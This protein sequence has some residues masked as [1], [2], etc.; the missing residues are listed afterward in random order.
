MP[1]LLW[2]VVTEGPSKEVA[3][4]G[5]EEIVA[6]RENSKCLLYEARMSLDV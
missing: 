6:G 1:G 5:L 4:E 2:I 3:A